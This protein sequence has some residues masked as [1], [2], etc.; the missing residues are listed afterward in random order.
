[1]DGPA[2]L[3]IRCLDDP[4]ASIRFHSRYF[5]DK[6]G[7]G[8]SVDARASGLDATVGPVEVWVWDDVALPDY[9]A[10]LAENFRG[11]TGERAWQT[12]H[13]VVRATF[14]SRG[15]VALTWTLQPWMSRPDAW[16]AS[17][18]TWFEAGAQMAALADDM[19]VFLPVPTAS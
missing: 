1:V 11:W 17:L 10:D 3:T 15:H 9:F 13:L 12:N 19:R 7:I 8:F 2:E 16:K 4:T 14:H 6:H 5:P 18:T